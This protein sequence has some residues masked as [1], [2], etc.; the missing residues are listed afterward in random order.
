MDGRVQGVTSFQLVWIQESDDIIR[1]WFP[2]CAFRSW[3]HSPYGQDTAAVATVGSSRN[4]LSLPLS[5][6][7]LQMTYCF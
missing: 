7:S 3:L 5:Q 4:I 1:L 6:R 2:G